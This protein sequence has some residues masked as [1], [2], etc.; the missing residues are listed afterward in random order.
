M[1]GV[2]CSVVAYLPEPLGEFVDSLRRRL[3]PRFAGWRAHVSILPPRMLSRAPEEMLDHLRGQCLVLDPFEATLSEVQTFWPVNGVVYLSISRGS[4]R[5][6]EFHQRLNSGGLARVEPYP[7][8]PHVTIAQE[9]DESETQA[10]L[11]EASREWARYAGTAS[12]RVESLSL[13]RQEPDQRWTDLAAVSLR[14]ALKPS[15]R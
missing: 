8:V 5:L 13:V 3:N 15:R 14:G 1:A 10:V 7:Y 4:D 12:F 11:R 9:L 6:T 2:T